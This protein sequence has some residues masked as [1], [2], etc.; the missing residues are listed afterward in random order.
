MKNVKLKLLIILIACS[1][2]ATAQENRPTRER[3]EAMK[4]GFITDRLNLS[5]EEAKVFWPV[6]N[7]YSDE[8]EKLRK[9]R[10]DNIINARENFDEMSDADLE[11]AVDSE[12]AFRQNEVDIIKKYHPQFKKVLPI[13]KVA[14]LY[15]AE[16]D[17][18]RKLLD[19]LQD[20]RGDRKGGER[21]GPPPDQMH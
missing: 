16:E 19:I 11:K 3:V 4:I 15:K 17:F 8:L 10:R 2:A 12:L 18:K 7:Q 6:Y 20:R 14:K 13:K 1:G 9:G 5:S 21:Q